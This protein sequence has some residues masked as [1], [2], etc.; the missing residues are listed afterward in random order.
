MTHPLAMSPREEI[1]ALKRAMLPHKHNNDMEKTMLYVLLG[2]WVVMEMGTM[3]TVASP[4]V[5]INWIRY[6]ILFMFGQMLGLERGR[7]MFQPGKP[8]EGGE[9]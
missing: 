5:S 1:G 2:V 6:L 9:S 3:F 8:P 4:P 7:E